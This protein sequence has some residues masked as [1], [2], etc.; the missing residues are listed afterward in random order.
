MNQDPV[1]PSPRKRNRPGLDEDRKL[2][3]VLL[4]TALIILSLPWIFCLFS[5][6]MRTIEQVV[7]PGLFLIFALSQVVIF[8]SMKPT[9]R[10]PAPPLWRS[11]LGVL[12]WLAL[13]GISCWYLVPA[14]GWLDLATL[15]VLFL[16]IGSLYLAIRRLALSVRF[17]RA[18]EEVLADKSLLVMRSTP[19]DNQPYPILEYYYLGE[20]R[21]LYNSRWIQDRSWEIGKA[22]TEN[23]FQVRIKYLPDDP[24]THKVVGV[25][26]LN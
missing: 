25:R 24:L 14:V 10:N 17:E 5:T 18:A 16:G 20:Y 15:V 4:M 11:S 1:V 19:G 2:R 22:I 26:I 3:R 13:I 7:F 6:Q 8:S 23:R 12:G 9:R 21:S